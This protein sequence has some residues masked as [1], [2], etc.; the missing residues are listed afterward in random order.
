MIV[1]GGCHCGMVRFEARVDGP[2]RNIDLF[3]ETFGIKPGDKM[4]VAPENRARIW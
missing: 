1:E 4:F 2:T 3:Y